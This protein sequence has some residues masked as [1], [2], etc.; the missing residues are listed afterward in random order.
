PSRGTPTI[1]YPPSFSA[2]PSTSIQTP[3]FDPENC[4]FTLQPCQPMR[5]R[6]LLPSCSRRLGPFVDARPDS[7]AE[8]W[9][10]FNRRNAA[11]LPTCLA[12]SPQSDLPAEFYLQPLYSDKRGPLVHSLVH[13]SR[14]PQPLHHQNLLCRRIPVWIFVGHLDRPVNPRLEILGILS[15]IRSFS[16]NRHIHRTRRR[17]RVIIHHRIFRLVAPGSQHAPPALVQ[18]NRSRHIRCV[19]RSLQLQFS[20]H[21]PVAHHFQVVHRHN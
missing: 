13:C 11:M 6:S 1:M 7:R 16:A 15:R 3:A 8:R 20:R 12:S 9:P 18:W 19:A 4:F 2:V 17:I 21:F 10:P 14:F 5:S